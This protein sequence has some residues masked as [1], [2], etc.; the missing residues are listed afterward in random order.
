MQSSV[1]RELN[2]LVSNNQLIETLWG[3]VN[4]SEGNLGNVA[5]LIARVLDT[6]A[7]KKREVAQ[8]GEVVQFDRFIDFIRTPP[9]RGCGWEPEKVEALLKQAKADQD[10]LRRWRAAV[11]R[12]KHVHADG[13]SIT[14]KPER[15]TSRAYTL[16]RLAADH[17]AIYQRVV[18]GELSANAAAIEAG[19]RQPPSALKQ[20]QKNWARAT[21]DER[22]LFQAWLASQRNAPA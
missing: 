18:A 20:L 10:L 5:P 17:P 3:V 19:L 7:W 21:E 1:K 13:D 12:P 8:I 9:L 16:T 14:I 22:A 11:T 6:G 2:E 4:R 15:G